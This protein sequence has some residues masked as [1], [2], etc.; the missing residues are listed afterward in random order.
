MLTGKTSSGVE[1]FL[2]TK[3]NL[4]S[5]GIKEECMYYMQ[6]TKITLLSK[7]NVK[8]VFWFLEIL[9]DLFVTKP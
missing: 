6:T 3:V 7:K 5:S 9:L 8:N 4:N 1:F 2:L